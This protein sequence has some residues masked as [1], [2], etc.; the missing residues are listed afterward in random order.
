MVSKHSK[1][2]GSALVYFSDASE[3]YSSFVNLALE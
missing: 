1:T 3:Y 2:L